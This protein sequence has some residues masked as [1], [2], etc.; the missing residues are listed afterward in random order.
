[1]ENISENI[2]Y[3]IVI[4]C[5]NEEKYIANCIQSILDN[6]FKDGVEILVC[7]GCS[8]DKTTE[9]IA[10]IQQKN[11]NVQLL[12]NEKQTT[13]YALNLGIE[14]AKGEFVMILGAH[15]MISDTYLSQILQVFDQNPDVKCVGGVLENYYENRVSEVI[16]KAMS[17]AFGVGNAHFRTGNKS[18]VVDTVAFGTYKKEV[19]EKIGAFDTDLARNQDDEFNYRMFSNDLKMYLETKIIAKYFVRAS[20]KKLF[21]QY[22]QYGFWKVFVN[23]KHKTVTTFRQLVPLLFVMFLFVSAILAIFSP[24]TLFGSLIIIVLYFFLALFFAS[25]QSSSIKDT[26]LI[27]YSFLIL[28]LSYGYGYLWGLI[29]FVILHKKPNSKHQKITR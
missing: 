2:R 29:W 25:K 26:F 11:S 20:F 17:S 3:S 6:S 19:F 15:S 28:H 23:K 18:G 1:M 13:P 12:V 5:R 27:A 8:T 10:E 7:D 22:F 4:P 21:K 9:V 16:G 14:H 24:I